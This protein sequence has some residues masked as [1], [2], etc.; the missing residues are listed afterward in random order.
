M[1]D[2]ARALLT[3]EHAL[4]KVE[5]DQE[6]DEYLR[7][8]VSAAIVLLGGDAPLEAD[9]PQYPSH[10]EQLVDAAVD[11]TDGTGRRSGW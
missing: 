2:P 3:L 4:A 5:T 1:A 7:S 11:W 6:T 10:R 9:E 8:A